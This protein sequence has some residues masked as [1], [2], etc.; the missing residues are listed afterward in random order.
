MVVS[1]FHFYRTVFELA[2]GLRDRTI[3]EKIQTGGEVVKDIEFP[4]VFKKKHA[5]FPGVN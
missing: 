2:Q 3:L 1:Y 4:G 5:E